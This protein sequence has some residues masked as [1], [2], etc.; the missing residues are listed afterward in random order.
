MKPVYF[1]LAL[2]VILSPVTA[3]ATPLILLCKGEVGVVRLNK[4]TE[5]LEAELYYRVD[6]GA[7]SNWG[8]VDVAWP[9]N[10]CSIRGARCANNDEFLFASW[11]VAEGETETVQINRR[12]GRV[13]DETL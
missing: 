5:T 3:S 9:E 1:T 2:A 6:D 13:K 7:F 8:P 11:P 12:T 10:R 4:P